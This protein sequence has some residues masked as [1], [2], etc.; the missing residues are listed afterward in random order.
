MSSTPMSRSRPA[1]T[2]A[3]STAL[4]AVEEGEALELR[5]LASNAVPAH[6]NNNTLN[7]ARSRAPR[8]VKFTAWRIINTG[9]LLGL[10]VPKAVAT[11]KGQNTAVNN[12]DW[13]LGV[14]WAL[15]SSWVGFVEQDSPES[16]PWFFKYDLRLV[17]GTGLVGFCGILWLLFCVTATVEAGLRSGYFVV[18]FLKESDSPSA[19]HIALFTLTFILCSAGSV[20]LLGSVTMLGSMLF[21]WFRS[22]F[23]LPFNRLRWLPPGFFDTSD[24]S[25]DYANNPLVGLPIFAVVFLCWVAVW[26]SVFFPV[27]NLHFSSVPGSLV[28]GTW[29]TLSVISSYITCGVIRTVSRWMGRP[30]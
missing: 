27:W 3:D 16:A 28:V 7:S 15:I 5:D 30:W 2:R 26:S 14:A 9:I 19:G 10:G 20:L 12:L 1:A 4:Q 29:I 21:G 22:E 24:W 8:A 6:Q 11:Y 17:L 25:L 23:Y 18:S 13:A